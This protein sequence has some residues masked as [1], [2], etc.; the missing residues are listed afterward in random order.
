M[1]RPVAALNVPP[2]C[3]EHANANRQRCSAAENTQLTFRRQQDACDQPTSRRDQVERAMLTIDSQVHAYDKNSPQRPWKGEPKGWPPSANADEMV[4][5]MDAV[6]V[7]AAINISPF[8][9]YGY[10]ASYA[11]EVQK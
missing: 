10:D 6:G 5:A 4:A 2:L 9:V 1:A 7:D 11:I 8:S 3:T